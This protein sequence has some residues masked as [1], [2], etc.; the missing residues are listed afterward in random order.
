MPNI[1]ESTLEELTYTIAILRK[2]YK[3]EPS[4]AIGKA[5]DELVETRGKILHSMNLN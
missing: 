2:Q 1:R 4:E 3:S 5:I